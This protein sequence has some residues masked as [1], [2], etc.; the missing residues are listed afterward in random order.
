MFEAAP[1][2]L[3]RTHTKNIAF[4]TICAHPASNA[5]WPLAFFSSRISCRSLRVI[6]VTRCALP[7]RSTSGDFFVSFFALRG[8]FDVSVARA[9]ASRASPVCLSKAANVA[10][11]ASSAGLPPS[12]RLIR[13]NLFTLETALTMGAPRPLFSATCRIN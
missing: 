2:G 10:H 8:S 3:G 6:P 5:C 1:R 13:L 9:S 11:T 12:L 7:Q 4:L